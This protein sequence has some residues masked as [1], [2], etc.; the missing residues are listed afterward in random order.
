M[1]QQNRPSQKTGT[2][3]AGVL[4]LKQRLGVHRIEESVT[5]PAERELCWSPLWLCFWL[6]VAAA[7][8]SLFFALCAVDTSQN[9]D[10]SLEP[11]QNRVSSQRSCARKLCF[12]VTDSLSLCCLLR[13]VVVLCIEMGRGSVSRSGREG[14]CNAAHHVMPSVP[15]PQHQ[16]PAREWRDGT[17]SALSLR[18]PV[19]APFSPDSVT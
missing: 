9:L 14:V 4:A 3:R 13:G 16:S 2:V 7:F 17:K 12:F 15:E 10:V 11:L 5:Q 19:L 18:L 6:G 1:R 8:F